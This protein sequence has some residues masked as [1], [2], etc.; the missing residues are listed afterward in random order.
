MKGQLGFS[1]ITQT[2]QLEQV[3]GYAEKYNGFGY[4]NKGVSSAYVWAG[5]EAYTGGMYVA[6][7]VFSRT[8]KDPRP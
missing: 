3:A 2:N 8:K 7:H 5:T 6:D 1:T 4:R